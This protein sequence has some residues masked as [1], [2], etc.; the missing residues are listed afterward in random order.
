MPLKCMK[1]IVKKQQNQDVKLK[2]SRK[3]TDLQ[4]EI[5]LF[6]VLSG[7]IT[8]LSEYKNHFEYFASAMLLNV[9]V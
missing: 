4:M 1:F 9:I 2:E 3:I 5:S 7:K 8:K 6:T